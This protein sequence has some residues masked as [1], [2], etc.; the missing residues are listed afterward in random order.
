MCTE[1]FYVHLDEEDERSDRCYT[2][3]ILSECPM[4]R[5]TILLFQR[6]HDSI[7]SRSQLY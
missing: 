6:I 3:V 7:P 5:F 2:V 1:P 4:G